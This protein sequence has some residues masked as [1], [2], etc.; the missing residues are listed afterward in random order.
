MEDNKRT[1]PSCLAPSPFDSPNKADFILL[2]SDD[3]LFH[4]YKALLV[5]ASPFFCNLLSDGTPNESHDSLPLYRVPESS[6][7]MAIVLRLCYPIHVNAVDLFDTIDERVLSALDKYIMDGPL[8]R[9]REI[10]SSSDITTQ[11]PLQAFGL[12]RRLGCDDVARAAA[13]RLLD[14]GPMPLHADELKMMSAYELGLLMKYYHSCGQAAVRAITVVMS[15]KAGPALSGACFSIWP[16]G[17]CTACSDRCNCRIMNAKSSHLCWAHDWFQ[18]FLTDVAPMLRDNPRKQLAV[19]FI[20]NALFRVNPKCPTQTAA[21]I[22]AVLQA[23]DQ[24]IQSAVDKV[25]LGI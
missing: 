4:V 19:D 21:G 11:K 8:T 18:S 14:L 13:R 5:L 17:N 25:S 24:D 6:S 1:D 12:A 16:S 20:D 23:L 3:V 22:K 10:V 9:L 2:T 15:L 7:T